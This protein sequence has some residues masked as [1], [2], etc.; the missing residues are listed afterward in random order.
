MDDLDVLVPIDRA[1]DTF[2]ALTELGWKAA[3]DL[4]D[5]T[6]ELLLTHSLGFSG[7]PL[8]AGNRGEVDVHWRPLYDGFHLG[9]DR[10]L[11]ARSIRFDLDGVTTRSLDPT[12]QFL[13]VCIHGIRWN[14]LAP[15][16][17]VADAIAVA[18]SGPLDWERLVDDARVRGVAGELATVTSYLD[19]RFGV[20]FP[21]DARVA[22]ER[23]RRRTTAYGRFARWARTSPPSRRATAAQVLV[24]M[25]AD[26]TRGAT[27]VRRV[28]GY[29][30][31]LK[32]A[33]GQP[34]MSG[35]ARRVVAAVGER[36]R[37][38]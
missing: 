20:D 15:I 14:P 8:T 34:T 5:T 9:V 32:D 17:W 21:L 2:A 16:R 11:W 22:L 24:V 23:L 4:E 28:R 36:T 31:Y 13:H 6:R 25:F 37:W 10:Q 18:R 35:V 19:G 30:R 12:D 27:F 1:R 33:F 7:P 29:P 38:S 26:R 3:R